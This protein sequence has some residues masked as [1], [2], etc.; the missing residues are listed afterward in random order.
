MCGIVGIVHDSKLDANEAL[1]RLRA[2]GAWQVHRGP[3][4]WGEFTAPGVVL[5]HNRLSIID[6]EGGAQ[7]MTTSDGDLWIVFNGEIYN[8]PALRDELTAKGHQFRSHHS[9]TETILHGYRQWGTGV[10]ARLEGMF[11][12]A[13]W[14]ARKRELILARDRAGIKPLTYVDLDGQTLV[15]ASELKSLLG[16]GLVERRFAANLLPEFLTFRTTGERCFVE[17]VRRLPPASYLVFSAPS[18]ASNG[19][20]GRGRCSGPIRYWQSPS[21]PDSRPTH[22]ERRAEL[23]RVLSGA[24]RSHLLSDVP[25]GV[26]LS[27]GVDSSVISA[28]ARRE[29]PLSAF[30][31]GTHSN[32]SELPFA[33]EVSR[34][35]GMPLLGRS[36][37]ASE[38]L[39]NFDLWAYYNDDPISDPSAL[40]LM[41]L[42]RHAREHGMK[43]MLS[44][45]GAD[46]LFGGYN[47]YL[48]L[49]LVARAWDW[50]P[51]P[52]RMSVGGRMSGRWGDYFGAPS[53]RFFG[54]GHLGS[55]RLKRTLVLPDVLEAGLAAHERL[56]FDI[57]RNDANVARQAMR[58]DREVRLPYDVLARTDR[59]TMAY[60]VEGRVPFLDRSVMEFADTLPDSECVDVAHLSGKPLLKELAAT[61]VP[62]SVVYRKKRGFDLPVGE[63]LR[64]RFAD[65]GRTFIAEREVPG[66]DYLG[67][68]D[69]WTRHSNKR[70]DH[71]GTLWAWLVLEQWYRSWF[72]GRETVRPAQV[73]VAPSV[74]HLLE[75]ARS[76]SKVAT[77]AASFAAAD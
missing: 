41:L 62:P 69:L 47:S 48:R 65:V 51:N 13:L 46:E 64:S 14:D 75:Q 18:S 21:K 15:F 36:V 68:E 9:D 30:S 34:A 20:S 59:A 5:G 70:A 57:D 39:S 72:L 32:L 2:M 40:A 28:L 42:T 33:R 12:I 11:A 31:I 71:S 56:S 66:L 61:L 26:Y 22:A 8:H 24:V 73:E 52:L 38:F 60:S 74:Q 10:F 45:E 44:G 4:A 25:L 63:W 58:W 29:T 76:T 17:G 7:P 49:V 16:S 35:L 27:G 37:E 77:S 3:D 1:K 50:V 23:L 67:L 53:L 54:S 19:A 6:L 55:I 43:V